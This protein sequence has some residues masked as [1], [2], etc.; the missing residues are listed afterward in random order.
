[1]KDLILAVVL[2]LFSIHIAVAGSGE[3]RG[4]VTSGSNPIVGAT[5]RVLELDRITHTGAKGEYIFSNIPPG[6][7]KVFVRVIG[8]ASM[9]NTVRVENNAA[10]T[11]FSLRESAIG[12]EEVV[13]SA[14]PV[15]R[16]ADE[17]YQ[18]AE[19][20]SMVEFHESPGSSFAEKISD[21]PGVTV[22]GNGSAPARPILRGL[23]DNRVLVLENGLR[24]GDIATYDPAHATPI[25]ALSISQI[26]VVRGPSSILYGPSTIGGLVN[27]ITN[28]IPT[29]S[30]NPFSGLVSLSG[31]SVSDEYS[32]FFN[33]VYSDGGSA[34]SVSGGGLHSQD[35]HIP[36]GT[37]NDGI[38]DFSLDRMPQ[39]F[40]HTDEASIGYSYQGDFGMIGIG[41]KFYEMNYGIPGTPP[42]DNWAT[43]GDPAATSRIAQ[44]KKSLELKSLLP[45]DGSVI[46]QV[47]LNANY[48][49]YNHSEY[50]TNQDSTGISDPQANHFH[51]QAFNATLQ[52]QHQ[53]F[54][55]FQGTIGLWA[56]I[57][58]LTIDGDQPLGPN[59]LT[60]VLAGYI[61][62][63]YFAAEDTRLEGAIRFDYN[64][65]HTLPAAASPDSV[66]QTLDVVQ[67][68]N[69]VTASFGAIQKLA[70]ELT[71]SL[72]LARSFRAP[73]VQELFAN[74]LDAASGTYSI[75]D[76]A[77]TPETG[78]GIDGSLKGNFTNFSFELTP[79][80]NFINNYI[81]G[82]LRGDTIQG[83]P[84][85]Q[86]SATNASLIGFE[87]SV[88][89]QPAQYFAV[90]AS[91]DFVNAED[92][93][94]NVPLPFTPP[95]RGLFK[96]SYQD[97]KYAGMVE[98]RLAASQT[99][100]G[101]G[102]TPTEGYGII[103]LGAGIRFVQE[104][105]LHNI[106]LHC[107]NLFDQVYRDNLSVIK[108]FI[109]QPARGFRLNYDLIF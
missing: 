99:R 16:T 49:D 47:K 101:D 3:I 96:L 44:I 1:M 30:S 75:G 40:N 102:D 63:E 71:A 95:M 5:V 81:Y 50:P 23:S 33:G 17:Q 61:Y 32:G 53:Q 90:K 4:T 26:D 14:S 57:E 82:F 74:G 54:D 39:S 77:L 59:S 72:S 87:A 80:A 6:T 88:M 67:T 22:R 13:V 93:K 9:T 8:Y 104:G 27:V 106:S 94:N 24:T 34:F 35:I 46:K 7:Y 89:L 98:W 103:N 109:P 20:K 70:P 58:Q 31:N 12:M 37:Y 65:I 43:L 79:Y 107:D 62:E 38:Q 36:T 18:S 84:V 28:T 69:A 73:T 91:A 64:R 51:K 52:F 85:R 11:S 76:A 10:E 29:A 41:G 97:E 55:K 45:V 66:F 56:N 86:F 108:D 100:L 78:F 21:L 83:L 25:E 48:V 19:S 60:T 105:L 15:A 68:S 2:L 92:T 42:N